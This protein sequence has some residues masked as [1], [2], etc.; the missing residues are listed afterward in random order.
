M[1]EEIKKEIDLIKERNKKVE[2]DKA[3][4]TSGVRVASVLGMTYVVTAIVF[5]FLGVQN[6]LLNALIPTVGFYLSTQS[7]PLLKIWWINKYY[8][9]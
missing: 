8:K 9:K 7:L 4:E 1:D 2:A 3:W 6:F 5:Y